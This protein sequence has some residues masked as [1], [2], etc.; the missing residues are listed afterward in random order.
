LSAQD[1]HAIDSKFMKI[2]PSLYS[3]L[4]LVGFVFAIA[5]GLFAVVSILHIRAIGGVPYYDPRLMRIYRW[6]F[7]LSS[8]ALTSSVIGALRPSTHRLRS[9]A[10]VC[11]LVVSFFWL[12]TASGE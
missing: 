12:F 8:I 6:G 9:V 3:K 7:L 4:S 1:H 10:V 11:A 5:S 2:T